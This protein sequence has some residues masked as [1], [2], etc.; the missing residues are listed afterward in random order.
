M[1]TECKCCAAVVQSCEELASALIPQLETLRNDTSMF[2][3]V[4]N[5]AR[6]SIDAGVLRMLEKEVA[7]KKREIAVLF[8]MTGFLERMQRQAKQRLAD[9]S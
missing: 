3:Q 2:E 6:N 1:A 4:I 8:R 9:R 7:A 5:S